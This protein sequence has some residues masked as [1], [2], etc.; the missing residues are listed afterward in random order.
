[1]IP[2]KLRPGDAICVVSPSTSLAVIQAETRRVAN[3]NLSGLG[4]H[5]TFSRNA[6][7]LNP[8]RSSSIEQR[9]ADLHD[10]FS[11]PQIKAVLTAIGGYNCN[12]LLEY[13]DDD[14]IRQHPKILCG[15]SD[16][17]ALG[18]AILAK[19]GLVTYSGPHYSTFG[20]R[21]GLEYTLEYFRR[22]LM[23]DG[24]FE[25]VPSG[26]WSDDA[27]Y[28][29]QEQREF[30]PNPGYLV[31]NPGQAE[32]R[33]VGGNLCT[34][35]LLQGTPYMPSLENTIL[36]LEDDSESRA[37]HIDRDLQS[38]LH[39]PG[40]EGVRCLVIGRFQVASQIDD[41]TL[42][43]LPVIARANLGHCT[44][45]MTFPIGGRARLVAEPG[46]VQLTILDH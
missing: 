27:W 19:T 33:L 40:F 7:A 43:R 29:H 41:E 34:F 24:P 32:G 30:I 14:L 20:M 3:K 42:R 37:E 17:T 39:L 15:F 38:L 10:A 4:L 12:Q 1:M 5:V 13:L 21:R 31:I 45:Q 18:N 46:Q 25:V 6:E 35:N 8:S 23:E 9:L 44:P 2:E 26:T 22:C 36:M 28:R 16:I 11:D